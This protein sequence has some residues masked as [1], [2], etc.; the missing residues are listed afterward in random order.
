VDAFT[1]RRYFDALR[2]EGV[3]RPADVALPSAGRRFDIYGDP[4]A[5]GDALETL[6]DSPGTFELQ[7]GG[8][9][10]GVVRDGVYDHPAIADHFAW[11]EQF[12]EPELH[13]QLTR[14]TFAC[15]EPKLARAFSDVY[16]RLLR[17]GIKPNPELA[18]INETVTF[19][20]TPSDELMIPR[21]LSALCREMSAAEWQTTPAKVTL[22]GTFTYPQVLADARD[23]YTFALL[24]AAGYR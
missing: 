19:T 14:I 5:L 3:L 16:E 9:S 21:T 6:S 24:I 20:A 10:F 4:W 11:L 23:R 12:P 2:S 18:V 8:T 13:G 1:L 7:L 17:E 15:N 22:E